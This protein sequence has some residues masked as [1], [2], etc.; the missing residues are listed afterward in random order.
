MKEFKIN[1]NRVQISQRLGAAIDKEGQSRLFSK[2]GCPG[3]W[4]GVLCHTIIGPFV[5]FLHE[6]CELL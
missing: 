2:Q 6:L 5:C 4:V 1:T 3:T